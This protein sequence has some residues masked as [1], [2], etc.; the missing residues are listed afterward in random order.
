MK[1]K[2][3]LAGYY[4]HRIRSNVNI[5]LHVLYNITILYT[6]SIYIIHQS[7]KMTTLVIYSRITQMNIKTLK[8][9][10]LP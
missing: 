3:P 6:A 5:V 8:L 1:K 7:G 2:T 9:N 4:K 10:I